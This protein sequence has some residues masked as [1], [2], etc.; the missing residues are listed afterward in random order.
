[1]FQRIFKTIISPTLSLALQL[2]VA[3]LPVLK[4]TKNI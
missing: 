2:G 4:S 1:M 3:L